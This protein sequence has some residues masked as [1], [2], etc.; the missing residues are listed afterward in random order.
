MINMYKNIHTEKW[1]NGNKSAK[2]M[3]IIK[4]SNTH[5]LERHHL[6]KSSINLDLYMQ[7]S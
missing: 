7:H 2:C 1:L 3:Q 6:T 4:Q 5:F